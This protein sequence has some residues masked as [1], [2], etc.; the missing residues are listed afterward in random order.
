[1]GVGRCGTEGLFGCVFPTCVLL[2][3]FSLLPARKMVEQIMR[4]FR[5][6]GL[7]RKHVAIHMGTPHHGRSVEKSVPPED[8]SA[9]ATSRS[10]TVE[11]T[12]TVEPQPPGSNP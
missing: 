11:V 2:C 7:G 8:C 6:V 1:M 9:F 10:D 5:W 3:F 4:C 12:L